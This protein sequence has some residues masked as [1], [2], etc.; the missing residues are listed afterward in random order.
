[1]G[2]I[3]TGVGAER[4]TSEHFTTDRKMM[5]WIT[6]PQ[7]LP[8]EPTLETASVDRI[9][10]QEPPENDRPLKFGN[11]ELASHMLPW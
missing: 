2:F 3:I 7:Q 8:Q 5:A 6:S 9:T 10:D 11:S 4:P 1:M